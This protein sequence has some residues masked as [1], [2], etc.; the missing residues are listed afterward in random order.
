MRW[1]RTCRYRILPPVCRCSSRAQH[2]IEVKLAEIKK[3]GTGCLLDLGTC[4]LPLPPVRR[5]PAASIGSLPCSWT[6]LSV[7]DFVQTY[8]P[9]HGLD[10]LKVRS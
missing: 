3:L 8:F 9:L 7:Q 4:Y 2:T 1:G 6:S 10:P 5:L